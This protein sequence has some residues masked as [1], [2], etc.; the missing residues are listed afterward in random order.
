MTGPL[1]GADFVDVLLELRSSC[2]SDPTA[3]GLI[4]EHLA[5]FC[6]RVVVGEQ[7]AVTELERVE[8]ALRR[9]A[10]PRRSWWRPNRSSPG[11]AVG[12]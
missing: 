11:S 1:A 10:A 4:D 6:R 8:G 7:E 12:A 5:V 2:C 3:V 9:L